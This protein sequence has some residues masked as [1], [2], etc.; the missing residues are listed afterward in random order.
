MDTHIRGGGRRSVVD[1]DEHENPRERDATLRAVTDPQVR[2]AA[3]FARATRRVRSRLASAHVL[4]GLACGSFAALGLALGLWLAHVP[5]HGFGPAASV[6]AGGLGGLLLARLR[7][8]SDEDLAM[9]LDVRLAS[10]E[11]ITTAFS[12]GAVAREAGGERRPVTLVVF[13]RA[14]AALDAAPRDAL[15]LPMLRWHHAMLPLC[16][17]GFVFVARLPVFVPTVIEVPPGTEIVRAH[18]VSGLEKVI[19]LAALEPRD[20]AQRERLKKLAADAERI[21]KKL[22]E[23]AQ[24]RELQADIAKLSDD[25]AAERMSLG[26]GEE[27]RG[28][29]AA[30]AALGKVGDLGG[31]EKALGDHDLTAFDD[32]MKRAANQAEKSSRDRVKQALEEAEAAA[33]KAGAKGVSKMLQEQRRAFEEQEKRSTAL[34]SLERALGSSPDGKDSPS[35]LDAQR[36]PEAARRLAKAMEKALEGLTDEQRKKLA[37]RMKKLASDAKSPEAKQ[38]L[39]ELA[40]RLDSPEGTKKLEEELR[41]ISDAPPASPESQRQQ[42]LDDAQRGLGG[43]GLIPI[44][45]GRSAAGGKGSNG[46]SGAATGNGGPNGDSG[47]GPSNKGPAPA[48]SAVGAADLRAHVDAPLGAGAPMPGVVTGRTSARPGETANVR[49]TGALGTVGPD[50]V[51]GVSRGDVPEEYREQVGRY[52]QP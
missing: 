7:R 25:I 34:R 27:R 47:R 3:S 37:E 45:T 2:F 51:L 21:R 44:P 52:F 15:R 32:E 46:A 43:N 11:A 38:S 8:P 23:G 39:K 22:E 16:G 6:V 42:A 19:A 17:L 5:G 35:A 1:V 24:K 50:E 36:D 40:Q 48:T 49:G 13:S 9:L 28:L 41:A 4:T 31:A 30:M 29:E 12:C 18:D 26:D 33:A 14:A 10:E 20:D